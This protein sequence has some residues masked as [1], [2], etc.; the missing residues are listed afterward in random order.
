M[1]MATELTAGGGTGAGRFAAEATDNPQLRAA[2][3]L[4]GGITGGL[5]PVALSY[6]PHDGGREAYQDCSI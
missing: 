6:T 1:T 2:F 3:E 4:A 5:T